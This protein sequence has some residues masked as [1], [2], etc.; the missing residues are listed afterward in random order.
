MANLKQLM[1][2]H[3]FLLS[4]G[5]ECDIHYQQDSGDHQDTQHGVQGQLL[6]PVVVQKVLLSLRL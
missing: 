3:R 4:P 2:L 6:W 1:W 5:P